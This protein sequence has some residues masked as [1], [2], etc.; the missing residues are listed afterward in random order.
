L[1]LLELALDLALEILALEDH[2]PVE[3]EFL[4]HRMADLALDQDQ[5]QQVEVSLV[6]NLQLALATDFLLANKNVLKNVILKIT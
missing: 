1:D 2:Q 5:D 3:W 4:A 6:G